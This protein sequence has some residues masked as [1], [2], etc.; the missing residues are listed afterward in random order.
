MCR[1]NALRLA[2]FSTLLHFM[3]L[4][5]PAALA[6]EIRV[7]EKCS[8]RDA[9]TTY[10]TETSTG[11]CRLPSWGKPRI[12]LRTDITLTEP[13]PAIWTDLTIDGFGHQIS[14]DKLHQVFVV[15]NHDL[16]ISNLHIVDGT[17]E[18]H[19]GA[20]YVSGG[21]VSLSN[22]S[23]KSSLALEEGGA[24][25]ARSS[26]V[27]II[28]TIISGNS[29]GSGGGIYIGDG[30]LNIAESALSDN[31]ALYGGAIATHLSSTSIVDG[32]IERNRSRGSGGG[33]AVADGGLQIRHSSVAA[34]TAQKSGGGLSLVGVYG[35]I[36]DVSISA[37]FAGADGG[38]LRWSR[39]MS[40]FGVGSGELDIFDSALTG[41]RAVSRGG[42]IYSNAR[43]I[44]VSNS[45]FNDNRA[46]GNGGALYSEARDATFTHVTFMRNQA[47]NGGGVFS[48]KPD[49]ITLRNSLIAG[50]TGGD[51]VGGLAGNSGN[52]IADGSCKPRY[53]GHPQLNRFA[54]KP[55]YF[56][57]RR[58][59]LA[60]NRGDPDYC[61]ETD[62]QGTPRPQ[63]DHCDIGAFEAVDWVEGEY[64]FR[65]RGA[66]ISPDII[67][68]ENC[69]L[70]DAIT[71]ANRDEATGGCI[72]GD[73]A[74]T[75]RLSGDFKISDSTP[76]ITS[77]IV[78][79]GDN[80]SLI[81]VQFVVKYGN[82]TVN[83]LTLKGGATS[84]RTDFNGG[85]FYLRYA[86]L[87]LNKVTQSDSLALADG[88]AIYSYDSDIVINDSS[89]SN[90]TAEEGRGGALYLD[91]GGVTISNSTFSQNS[92]V[93]SGG[94]IY[95]D[96]S[97]EI[98]I[99]GSVFN[100]NTTDGTGGA[101][102]VTYSSIRLQDSSLQ[103]NGA[104]KGGAIGVS[105]YSGIELS[106]V[107]FVD[108]SADECPKIFDLMAD[109]C[110]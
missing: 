13:L 21:A 75:I 88:G 10:N 35:T 50:S 106:D 20:I 59:S 57:L 70:A 69:S 56:P 41:N 18:E 63:G 55:S 1:T 4:A 3:L 2:L 68:D 89:F 58:E 7:D 38:G 48:R 31:V 22:S 62:Q 92:G 104:A 67:V 24:I 6:R 9:I 79:E 110:D 82:L 105:Y 60:I 80:H 84:F 72:A 71:S 37:N 39:S 109:R 66:V 103:R 100:D 14:G 53:S 33:I 81:H 101:I 27:S 87:Q 28:D 95:G 16:S 45:T 34:N 78:I 47:L 108:N 44:R 42:G 46:G 85:A 99:V 8:L 23:I 97:S 94:A 26:T 51:C 90:N 29:A 49:A 102:F 15:Y 77:E 107:S 36:R 5:P 83:N 52:W 30:E 73:G 54:G 76:D 40:D 17:S 65:R 43:D 98:N 96:V 12:N 74:D 25:Y 11:G 91:E 86:R 64:D 61:L 19:G 32:V 93:L